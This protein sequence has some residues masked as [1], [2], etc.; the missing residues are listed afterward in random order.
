MSE[1]STTVATPGQTA[2][3]QERTF[4]QDELNAIVEDRLR[5]EKSKYADYDVLKAK[6]SKFDEAEEASKTEL[7][8]MTDRA[9]EL[10]NKLDSMTKAEEIRTIRETVSKETGVP[11]SLL[12][13][14]TEEACKEQAKAI[15][16]FAKPNYPNVKDG[17][18]TQ[19]TSGGQARDQFK[20]WFDSAVVH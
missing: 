17:G 2:E 13:A 3:T 19:H 15:S 1:N 12:T 4:T 7:Q 20:E 11:V 16:E 18:E 6:A 14:D 9:N 5:R 8:K 10:Q